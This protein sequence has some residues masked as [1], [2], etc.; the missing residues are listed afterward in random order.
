MYICIKI[1]LKVSLLQVLGLSGFAYLKYL[2]GVIMMKCMEES[3]PSVRIQKEKRQDF[4]WGGGKGDKY[5][6][7]V[8][9]SHPTTSY[10]DWKV[11]QMIHDLI[12]FICLSG[13]SFVARDRLS[14][15]FCDLLCQTPFEHSLYCWFH[16]MG[17]YF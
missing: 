8:S 12:V 15:V 1:I 2:Q 3:Y 5:L 7:E 17:H 6:F 16:Q 11:E 14:S 10:N 13:D 9:D 4:F